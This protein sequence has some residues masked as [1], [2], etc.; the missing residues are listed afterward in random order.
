M[1]TA[2]MTGW[3]NFTGQDEVQIRLLWLQST[4]LRRSE[5]EELHFDQKRDLQIKKTSI[6]KLSQH[7]K[8]TFN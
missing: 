7:N 8:R 4:G 6:T 3:T 2:Q 1:L 5:V